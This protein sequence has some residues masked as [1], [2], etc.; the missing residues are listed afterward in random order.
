MLRL[1]GKIAIVTGC[2]SYAPG[3]SNGKAIAALFARQGATVLGVDIDA[4]TAEE[5]R[6]I[7]EQEGNTLHIGACDVTDSAQVDALVA[8][9]VARFGRLNI[10]V[11]NVG[12]SE[13]GTPVSM[14]AE[15]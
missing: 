7:V 8:G 6:R 2:G 5:T 13:P 15:T 14:D 12:R 3:W 11:N 9:C 1:D 10:L 4:G